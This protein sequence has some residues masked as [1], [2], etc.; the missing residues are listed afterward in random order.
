MP[1][2]THGVLNL[3][4]PVLPHLSAPSSLPI[5]IYKTLGFII[6]LVQTRI[7]CSEYICMAREEG[8]L[9]ENMWNVN[10]QSNGGK[11]VPQK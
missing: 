1:S 2:I 4:L 5:F 3:F 7:M 8:Q 10:K 9:E 11:S 6:S